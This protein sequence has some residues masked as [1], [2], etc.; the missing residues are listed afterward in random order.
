MSL[1][2]FFYSQLFVTPELPKAT[3]QG[4]TVIVTGANQGLGKEAVRHI[5]RLGASAVVIGCRNLE[6][7]EEAKRDIEATTSCH[8]DVIKVWKIDLSS[9][10]SVKEFGDRAIK[11]LP[12][13]D[14]VVQNAGI[15]T[16]KYRKVEEDESSIA[17]NV[18][19]PFLLTLMLLPKLKE[20]ATKFNVRPMVTVV[21]SELGGFASFSERKKAAPGQLFETMS[22]ES[23]ADM[24][25]RYPNSKLLEILI[26]RQLARLRPADSFPVTIDLVN[27]GLCYSSLSREFDTLPLRIAKF[28]AFN[29]FARTTEVGSRTL[30]HGAGTGQDKD[31]ELHGQ[32]VSDCKVTK[33]GGIPDSSEA[34]GLSSQ[35]WEE[36]SRKLEKIRPGVTK[37]LWA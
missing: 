6:S 23:T 2:D 30:V 16:R 25:S 24:S 18:I 8:K 14:A 17:V 11:S 33:S 4:K 15:N 1:L 20:T 35:L 3:F 21:T 31:R 26:V 7:G 12:R 34:E 29:S 22:N 10:E 37:N 36:L 32:Y 28:I 9:Y 19:S 13:I 27:P 5:A